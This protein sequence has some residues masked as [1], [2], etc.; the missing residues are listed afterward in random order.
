MSDLATANARVLG[1]RQAEATGPLALRTYAA[2]ETGSNLS[3][4]RTSALGSAS[5]TTN[6]GTAVSN[7]SNLYLG[8]A[9]GGSG[10][11]LRP[12]NTA[13]YPRIHA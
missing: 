10:A 3:V 5:L 12:V 13:Y 9:T 7:G 6:T 4:L 2:A 8:L 11:E 1:S